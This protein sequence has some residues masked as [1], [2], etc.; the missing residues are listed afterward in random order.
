MQILHV[1][2]LLA[3]VS[4]DAHMAAEAYCRNTDSQW[5]IAVCG[6]GFGL[7]ALAP[8]PYCGMRR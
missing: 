6:A 8:C 5:D 2:M 4:A 3:G 1:Q 7:D